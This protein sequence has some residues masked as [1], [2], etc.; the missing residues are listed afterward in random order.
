MD[1]N[2]RPAVGNK[3]KKSR[4]SIGLTQ[5]EVANKLGMAYQQYQKYENGI[6]E[7][8]YNQ[9]IQLCNILEISAD[10]LFGLDGY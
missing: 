8:N 1:F 7:L 3:L 10:Y 2:P 4:I 6:Y 9:I 5:K